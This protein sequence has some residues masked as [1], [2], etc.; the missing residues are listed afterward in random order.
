[1]IQSQL[2]DIILSIKADH[3][4]LGA[5]LTNALQLGTR[6]VISINRRNVAIGHLL[7][8][9]NKYDAFEEG[10]TFAS[11]IE[12]I[13]H[14]STTVVLT[15]TI[16]AETEVISSTS[17]SNIDYIIDTFVT[18]FNAAHSPQYIAFK[19]ENTMYVYSYDVAATF[20]DLVSFATTSTSS[21][22]AR[23]TNLQNDQSEIL[24]LWNPITS[25]DL[26]RLIKLTRALISTNC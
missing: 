25:D 9:L 4:P 26:C 11:K 17:A 5:S 21:I 6:K 22:E 20:T 18:L 14:D 1:M 12:F 24:D 13:S 15:L 10:V 19:F 23:V 3:G 7:N 8:I 16:G 2:D